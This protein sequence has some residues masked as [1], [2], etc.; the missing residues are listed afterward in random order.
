[1]DA[2][3]DVYATGLLLYTLI[4]GQGPFGHLTDPVDLL[5]AHV[6]ERPPLLSTRARQSVPPSLDGV[7]ERALE[8]LPA[9]RYP[10]AEA[11]ASDLRR[12][13]TSLAPPN[14]SVPITEPNPPDAG[15]T[16]EGPTLHVHRR[17][18]KLTAPRTGW[19]TFVA[20]AI[21]GAAGSALVLAA[22]S[23]VVP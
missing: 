2:R 14:A 12:V 3:T 15:R 22:L 6:M 10:S 19:G 1:V 8:K 21:L 18:A 20:L 16:T 17:Q 9:N 4:A 11:F 5:K 13:A 23:R 7:V